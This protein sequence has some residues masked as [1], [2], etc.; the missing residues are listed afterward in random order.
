MRS[1]SLRAFGRAAAVSATL[2]AMLA[3]ST[4]AHAGPREDIHRSYDTSLRLFND[5]ELEQ[6]S[7][8]IDKAIS[9]AEGSGAASDPTLASL[10]MMRAALLYSS[11]GD[12]AKAAISTA[13]DR[14]LALNYYVVV[15]QEVRSPALSKYLNEAKGRAANRPTDP[16][17]HQTPAAACGEALR[18]EALLG[19]PDGG[20]AALYW[21]KEGEAGFD[22]SIEMKVFS[23]VAEGEIPAS[24]HGDANIEYFIYA[25]DASLQPVANKGTQE[26]PIALRQSC[27]EPVGPVIPVDGG[28]G[29]VGDDKPG[30]GPKGGPSALPRVW[31]NIGLG[32][33]F[34]LARGTAELS[35]RQYFPGNEPYGPAQAACAIARWYAGAGAL[36]GATD[37][38][39]AA[40]VNQVASGMPGGAAPILAAYS[41]PQ[42]RESCSERQEINGGFASAPFHIAPEVQVRVSKRITLG[43]YSRLQVVSGSKVFRDS[44]DKS[45]GASFTEDVTSPSP[46]EDFRQKPPFSWAIGLKF[47]Y[48]FLKDTAKF[49]LF[50]GAYAGFGTARLRVPM[51]FTNDLNGNSVPDGNEVATNGET[52]GGCYPVWPYQG[53]CAGAATPDAVLAGQVKSSNSGQERIDTVRIGPGFAGALFGFNYQI[54]KNFALYGELGVGGWFPTTSSMLVDLTVG[55]AITF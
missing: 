19:V 38:G 44:T 37:A 15:P 26:A 22:R 52:G 32:T 11:Q 18:F 53:A 49:R 51:G 25:F 2:V 1:P 30:K 39:Y 42:V 27:E 23:N 45:L 50:G 33:G 46:S 28:D 12:G 21:R 48:Y 24:E 14:A 5:L 13:L 47:R 35:Y 43:L 55:P 17:L 31:I 4:P 29:D 6:A 10:Y 7:A 41:D 9:A 36:P 40:A 34:G 54:V 20:Q 16:I 8:E 3:L